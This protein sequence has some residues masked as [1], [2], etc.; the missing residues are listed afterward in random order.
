[1]KK[2]SL[3][4]SLLFISGIFAMDA[5]DKSETVQEDVKVTMQEHENAEAQKF[6]IFSGLEK[7][8][9]ARGFILVHRP[10]LLKVIENYQMLPEGI[11]GKIKTF[12]RKNPTDLIE[13]AVAKKKAKLHNYDPVCVEQINQMHKLSENEKFHFAKL[14]PEL[15]DYIKLHLLPDWLI[16]SPEFIISLLNALDTSFIEQLTTQTPEIP[17]R[18][19]TKEVVSL[20]VFIFR[21]KTL[22]DKFYE[23]IYTPLP[24]T[25]TSICYFEDECLCALKDKDEIYKLAKSCGYKT[26]RKK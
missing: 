3:V 6:R 22:N 25:P 19:Q 11:V 5:P 21:L 17:Q 10:T 7:Y 13:N 14:P 8:A 16:V 20:S 2:N 24:W 23:I 26:K 9:S 12:F 18:L 15:I 4:F 1:M